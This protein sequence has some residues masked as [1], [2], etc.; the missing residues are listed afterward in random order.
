L[1]H[2]SRTHEEGEVHIVP[3]S[4][5]ALE[6]FRQLRNI[7][8]NRKYL[9]S[10]DDDRPMAKTTLGAAL[11]KMGY[12]DKHSPHGLRRRF[13]SMLNKEYQGNI[14]VWDRDVIEL[15]LSH[16]EGSTRDIYFERGA[17]GLWEKN[18]GVSPWGPKRGE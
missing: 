5:Q 1:G 10:L 17:D 18:I 15:Q 13:S 12:K 6:I 9:L 14:K 4:R 3:L 8:A 11:I 7:N 16:L 2:P